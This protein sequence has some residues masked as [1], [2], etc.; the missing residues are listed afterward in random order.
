MYQ[1]DTATASLQLQSLTTGVVAGCQEDTPSRLADADDVAGCRCAHDT[2]LTDQELL[3]AIGSTD[4]GNGLGDL[5][6]PVTAITANDEER[7]IDALGDGL[8]DAGDESFRVV[9][10]LEDLDLLAETR[11]AASGLAT[12]SPL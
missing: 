6:V 4:L 1:Q 9:L 3:N 12:A 2:V 11:T 8:E 10:L 7:A 5:W